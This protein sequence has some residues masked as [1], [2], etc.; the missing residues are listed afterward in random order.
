MLGE[1]SYMIDILDS[2]QEAT[3]YMW[4]N[5]EKYVFSD[6]VIDK[7]TTLFATLMNLTQKI[8]KVSTF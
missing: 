1:D 2:A 7:G 4:V 5:G 6:H 8:H 3:S